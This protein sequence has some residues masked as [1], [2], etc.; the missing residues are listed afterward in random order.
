MTGTIRRARK[1]ALAVAAL[2]AA[3][4]VP[5]AQALAADAPASVPVSPYEPGLMLL[6]ITGIFLIGTAL[7]R[8]LLR[9]RMISRLEW[10]SPILI[11]VTGSVWL[12]LQVGRFADVPNLLALLEFLLGFEA[13]I[14]VLIPVTRW[15]LPTRAMRTR[16]GVPPLL[17]GMA[18]VALAL[19]GMF[20]LLSWA[21]PG[22]NFTPVFVTS[23][24]VSIVLGLALQELLS[25]L[26]AGIVLGVERPFTVGEWVQI[27]QAEGEVVELTWRTTLVRTRNGD[28]LLIPNNVAARELVTNFD[29]PGPEH[30][31]KIH[32]CLAYETP[33]G[34]A[35]DALLDA[36]S[37]VPEV[38][39]TPA[40]NVYLKEFQDS[41]VLY[42]LRVW[43]DNYASLHGIESEV[44]KEVWYACKRHDVTIPFPQRDVNLRTIFPE[45]SDRRHR[46]VATAGLLRGARFA[47]GKQPLFIGRN[48]D[49]GIEISDPQVSGRHAVI[50]PCE[51][52]HVLRDLGSRRGT[53][54]ND[55]LVESARLLPGDEI[56][57]GP[58]TLIYETQRVPHSKT[59]ESRIVPAPPGR[60]VPQGVTS[61]VTH[62]S[63]PEENSEIEQRR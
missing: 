59:A 60:H 7:F 8:L 54:V 14:F 51:D 36:A 29:R 16:R 34:V 25:N 56:C 62:A 17:R 53:R 42:E 15:V 6:A 3:W 55:V 33:C 57:V 61:G 40:P 10:I 28:H 18:V 58:V 50:E 52:G 11:F 20:I 41:A 19:I 35:T 47:L 22:F 12:F 4:S 49:C 26:M 9:L 48:A 30:L 1:T 63:G 32:I 5:G 13:F 2:A 46:L 38:L 39:R 21:F 24:V 44:R 45:P 37:R 27:G 43:I 23:G 31:V